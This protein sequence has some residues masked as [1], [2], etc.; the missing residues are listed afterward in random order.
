MAMK[1]LGNLVKAITNIG[2]AMTGISTHSDSKALLQVLGP[3][4]KSWTS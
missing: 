2:K 1:T 4:S 3:L